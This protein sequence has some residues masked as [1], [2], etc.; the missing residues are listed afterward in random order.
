MTLPLDA[1]VTLH[2]T[3][4]YS[5]EKDPYIQYHETPENAKRFV[6]GYNYRVKGTHDSRAEMDGIRTIAIRSL[7]GKDWCV[8]GE[9]L[10]N[11]IA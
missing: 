10:P 11:Y 9:P 5:G 1:L 2:A 4:I 3:A 6:D 7:V 8:A